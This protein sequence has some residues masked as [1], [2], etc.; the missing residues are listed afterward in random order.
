MNKW[1]SVISVIAL[2]AG[3]LSAC[4]G[5]SG[6][7]VK[8]QQAAVSNTKNDPVTITMGIRASYLTDTE[9]KRYITDPVQKKYSHISIQT[10]RIDDKDNSFQN[11]IAT[12]GLPDINFID[13]LTLQSTKLLNIQQDLTEIVK[14]H[15][16]DLSRFNTDLLDIVKTNNQT[17]YLVGFPYVVQFN[18]LYYNKD[19][20]NK[21]GVSYPKDG[22]TWPETIEIAK[23]LTRNEGGIQYRGLEP[24]SVFRPGSQLSLPLVD[25]KTYKSVVDTD[26]WKSV[27]QLWKAIYD[28]PGNNKVQ[29]F[30][31][32]V[33]SFIKDQNIAMLAGLNNLGRLGEIKDTWTN[34]DMASY[35]VFPEKP[36]IGTQADMHVMLLS[37]NSKNK[38]AAFQV[39]T[40]VLSDEVQLDMVHMGKGSV[41]KDK[42][43][44]EEFGQN[45]DFMKGKNIQAAFQTKPAKAYP[46]TEFAGYVFSEITALMGNMVKNNLDVNT[47]VRQYDEKVNKYIEQNR[48][49]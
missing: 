35:P 44:Q 48:K 26:S 28:I 41:L 32:G 16:Y 39:M 45:L 25:P 22:M 38:D 29:A 6:S 30:A 10:V 20:F 13:S 9:I 37:P 33:N 17:D 49:Q 7:T 14:K 34:W 40:T 46:P 47:A 24:D 19:I 18:A 23:K 43:F 21:F 15:N 36:G 12:G 2:A 42:K 8:K 11:L 1:V 31:S 5:G 3:L 27:L 4:G